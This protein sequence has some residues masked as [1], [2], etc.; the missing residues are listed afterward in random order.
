M[1]RFRTSSP[2]GWNMND[3]SYHT[4]LNQNSMNAMIQVHVPILIGFPYVFADY[5]NSKPCIH[6]LLSQTNFPQHSLF[7]AIVVD[8]ETD[9]AIIS[10]GTLSGHARNCKF[11]A[12]TALIP[13]SPV[14]ERIVEYVNGIEFRDPVAYPATIKSMKYSP[15]PGDTTLIGL[16]HSPLKA[17]TVGTS[18][19]LFRLLSSERA[20]LR[21]YRIECTSLLLHSLEAVFSQSE[22]LPRFDVR[23]EFVAENYIPSHAMYQ[24]LAFRVQPFLRLAKPHEVMKYSNSVLSL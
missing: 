21:L 23:G 3:P 9:V 12:S 16:Y 17:V 19:G 8:Q 10:N 18:T 2:A 1:G 24:S 6:Q 4:G 11:P 5:T 22:W 20:F 14:Q 7:R 15:R 13:N